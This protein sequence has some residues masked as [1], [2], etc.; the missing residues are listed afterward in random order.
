MIESIFTREHIESMRPHIQ[1]TVDSLLDSMIKEGGEKPIELVEKFSLPLPSFVSFFIS[2]YRLQL[3]SLLIRKLVSAKIIYGILGVPA[4][5]LEYL[6]QCNA[7][8]SN[9]SATATE[10]ANANKC[11]FLALLSFFI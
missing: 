1:K 8:R 7:V 5:D 4:K 3:M 10:A 6:T 2:D 9:G 11:D